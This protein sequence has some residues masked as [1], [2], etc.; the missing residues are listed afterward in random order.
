[1]NIRIISCLFALLLLTVG[2]Q[3]GQV[4]YLQPAD[5][6]VAAP[7][8]SEV[9]GESCFQAWPGSLDGALA[10]YKAKSGKSAWDNVN[11]TLKLGLL[12]ACIKMTPG[13]EGKT[14]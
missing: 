9:L 1:M 13:Q 10:A 11:L 12:E 8:K 2:C 6:D 4:A 14:K 3:I 5:H 7:D